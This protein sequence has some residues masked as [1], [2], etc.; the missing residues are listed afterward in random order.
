MLLGEYEHTIDD[1][2]RLTLPA[3]FRE[4]FSDGCVVTRGLDGCLWAWT[5]EGWEWVQDVEPRTGAPDS[6]IVHISWFEADAF[7]R[8]RDARLPTE[9]E[10]EKAVLSGA[11]SGVYEVW[12]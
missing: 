8:S 1:K 10:W 3:K 5:P 2:N 9:F 6:P 11:V 7:A 12:E 4:A